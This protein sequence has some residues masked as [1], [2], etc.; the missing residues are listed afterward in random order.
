LIDYQELTPVAS[1]TPDER[2]YCRCGALLAADNPTE[3]CAS[4][5]RQLRDR[6]IAPRAVSHSFWLTAQMRDAFAAQHIGLVAR[7]YRQHPHHEAVYGAAGISQ[8]LLGQWLGLTQAQVSRVENGRQP[9]KNID[10]LS[11]WA[12]VLRIPPDLLWFD[13]P[14][15]RRI[16]AAS[17]NELFD[18]SGPSMTTPLSLHNGDWLPANSG[19]LAD[20]LREGAELPINPATVTRLVHEWLVTEPPQLVEVESGRRI[21]DN[22]VGKIERRIAEL[23]RI[24]DFVAGGDLH[25]LVEQELRATAALLR[26]A[27]YTEPLGRRLLVAIGELCQLAGWVVGDAGQYATAAHYYSVGVKAAHAANS[28]GLA[29]NLISTLAYQVANV[30]NPREA[31]L[32]A[33]SAVTGAKQATPTVKALFKERLAWAHAKAGERRPAERTLAAV[34]TA[35][36]QRAPD[37]EPERVYWLNEA[38]IAIMA[39]RCY[40]ELGQ[41]ER[42]VPLL[43]GVLAHYPERHTRELALYTSWLAEAHIQLGA[44]DEAVAAAT[45]TLELTSQI[46]SARSDDRV[47]LLRRK[48]RPYK[49]V[50]AVADFAAMVRELRDSA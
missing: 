39:G 7:A 48:L 41:G 36:E 2:R 5:Q 37:D 22:L 33:Q 47:N 31:V 1:S 42:A 9:I 19:E 50:P 10:T 26:E 43:S 4:C 8:T 46:T 29:G 38:E 3:R 13:L 12:R 28:S 18:S 34:E 49:D 32:L 35:Y 11:H 16:T 14:G 40:V 25:T 24:D 23:R 27:R 21:G 6:L 45:R 44:V 30:G 17:V 20:L 15:S